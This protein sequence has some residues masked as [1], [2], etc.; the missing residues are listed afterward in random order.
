MS[1][2]K[3]WRVFQGPKPGGAARGLLGRC[4]TLRSWPKMPKHPIR[5]R[6]RGSKVYRAAK[7]R[8]IFVRAQHRGTRLPPDQLS[9]LGKRKGIGPFRVLRQTTMDFQT[10][11]ESLYCL[12]SQN[13]VKRLSLAKPAWRLQRLCLFVQAT[14]VSIL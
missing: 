4:C 2:T 5:G 1:H 7:G 13:R 9:S 11:S 3:L 6:P 8:P 10:S 12:S 14:Q